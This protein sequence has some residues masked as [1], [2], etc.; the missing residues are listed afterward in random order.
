M[1]SLPIATSDCTV[2]VPPDLAIPLVET[3][4]RRHRHKDWPRL[5]EHSHIWL[6]KKRLMSADAARTHADGLRYTNLIA[7][8]Y[9]GA[10]SAA[11]EVISDF[12]IWFFVWDDFHGCCALHRRDREW[13][14][15]RDSLHEALNSPEFYLHDDDPLIAGLA[16]CVHRFNAQLSE[17]W[18]KRFAFHFH[19]VI[20]GYDWEYNQRIAGLPPS[21]ETYTSLRCRTFGYHVWLDCLELAAGLELLPEVISWDEYRRAGMASQEFSGWYNDLCSIPKEL[22]AGEIH[23]LGICLMRQHGLSLKQALAEMRQRIEARV[24]DFLLAEQQVLQ[25]LQATQLPMEIDIATRH[26]VFNMRNWISSVYWFHH[27]SARYRVEDW[28]D[29]SRPPYISAPES[30]ACA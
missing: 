4:F 16:D 3:A 2:P 5:R 29:S 12:S 14:R 22:A 20:E 19:Q 26:C 23:N 25:R 11:L 1:N 10:P 30:K 18:A 27:E 6:V 9:V 8:Y 17:R 15:L 28:Q 21:V 24:N 7:D 13:Q